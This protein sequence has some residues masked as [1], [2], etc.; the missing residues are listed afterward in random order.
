MEEEYLSACSN[1]DIKSIES[2]LHKTYRNIYKLDIHLDNEKALKIACKNNKLN[3]IDYLIKYGELYNNRFD[4]RDN[5]DEIMR[6]ACR[7]NYIDI[8]K[9]LMKYSIKCN[10]PYNLNESSSNIVYD[11]CKSNSITLINYLIGD[12]EFNCKSNAENIYCKMLCIS[13]AEC[14]IDVLKYLLYNYTNKLI[15]NT[16]I[17]VRYIGEYKSD[18]ID[19]LKFLLEYYSIKYEFQRELIYNDILENACFYGNINVVK[20]IFEY[21]NKIQHKKNITHKMFNYACKSGNVDLV[22]FFV[23]FEYFEDLG[24]FIH[25]GLINACTLGYYD[26]VVYLLDY[27]I[28]TCRFD[29]DW[30]NLFV[31]SCCHGNIKLVKFILDYKHKNGKQINI[32]HNNNEAFKNTCLDGNIELYKFLLKYQNKSNNF[33]MYFD[34]FILL[35]SACKNGNIELI[36]FLLYQDVNKSNEI[37]RYTLIEPNYNNPLYLAYINENE[38]AFRFI[39]EYCFKYNIYTNLSVYCSYVQYMSSYNDNYYFIKYIIYLIK[40][41]Y[42]N[43]ILSYQQQL[44]VWNPFTQH[45]LKLFFVRKCVKQYSTKYNTIECKYII[46]NNI[47]CLSSLTHKQIINNY[48]F[49]TI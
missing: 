41:N 1:G 39:I 37:L 14:C 28:S 21:S 19:T 3:V 18:N 16:Y 43:T 4:V 47:V 31:N 24:N 20:F 23:N 44:P 33:D 8:V 10:K 27:I 49:Y 48:M 40:H 15:C 22:A 30:N 46:N 17:N 34:N 38:Q 25:F 32:Y 13:C 42:N 5:D 45:K 11:A 36:N 6:I 26:I 29:I 12:H 9:Y 2:I 35:L 7:H